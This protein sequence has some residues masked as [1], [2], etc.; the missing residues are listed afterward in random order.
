MNAEQIIH[1]CWQDG[2]RLRPV[3]EYRLGDSPTQ[4]ILI[5]AVNET[6]VEAQASLRARY[7][8]RLQSIAIYTG[9]PKPAALH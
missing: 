2:I 9:P 6:L 3:F 8:A 5:G 7:G 1:Q 4:L